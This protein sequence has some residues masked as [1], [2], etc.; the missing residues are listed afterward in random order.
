MKSQTLCLLIIQNPT[1]YTR[2]QV[3]ITEVYLAISPDAAQHSF[4]SI[5][6][7]PSVNC[8][9]NLYALLMP[10]VCSLLYNGLFHC[11]NHGHTSQRGLGPMAHRIWTDLKTIQIPCSVEE[12]AILRK[13]N[14]VNCF[15]RSYKLS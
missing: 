4:D 9:S 15:K 6:K 7:K 13:K 5:Q 2:M 12:K 8:T 11:V 10:V 14:L 3:Q 1:L